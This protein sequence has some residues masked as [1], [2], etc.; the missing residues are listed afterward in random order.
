MYLLLICI[1]RKT[2]EI[3][4]GTL[5]IYG[6]DT[7]VVFQEVCA[8]ITTTATVHVFLVL[9]CWE[10]SCFKIQAKLIV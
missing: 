2:L 9:L 5:V 4:L 7:T 1:A 10:T 3:L 6:M 8:M